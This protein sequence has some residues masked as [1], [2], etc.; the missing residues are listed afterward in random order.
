MGAV[1]D[2]AAAVIVAGP[3][4]DFFPPE[5]YLPRLPPVRWDDEDDPEP[6]AEPEE[7]DADEG[8]RDDPRPVVPLDE[9]DV[10]FEELAQ[11]G[12]DRGHRPLGVVGGGNNIKKNGQ[13]P[14]DDWPEIRR[15]NRGQLTPRTRRRLT[16]RAS[17]AWSWR[18]I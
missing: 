10:G 4:T 15:R 5:D 7:D 8:G 12:R 6:D 11:A 17:A 9:R 3:K 1:P 14:E 18:S 13:S 2:D 16:A